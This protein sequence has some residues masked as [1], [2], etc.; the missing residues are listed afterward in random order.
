[1][2]DMRIPAPNHALRCLT[3][4]LDASQSSLAGSTFPR[5]S[6]EGAQTTA[7]HMKLGVYAKSEDIM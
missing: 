5:C 6:R 2:R 4:T 7:A 3:R 1:M